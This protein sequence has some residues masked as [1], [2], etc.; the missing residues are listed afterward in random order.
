VWARQTLDDFRQVVISIFKAV[1]PCKTTDQFNT[2]VREHTCQDSVEVPARP[3][4]DRNPA[5]CICLPRS[6]L[7]GRLVALL[8]PPH[9]LSRVGSLWPPQRLGA[10]QYPQLIR[11]AIAK[12]ESQLSPT[13]TEVMRTVRRPT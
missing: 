11:N 7:F 5:R 4:A 2:V 9:P 10:M 6:R 12:V 3:P 1:P 8:H 13:N